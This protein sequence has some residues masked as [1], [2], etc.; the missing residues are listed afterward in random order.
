MDVKK[1]R[2]DM[3][4]S[5]QELADL[6]G[7]PKGRINAWEQRG[8]TPKVDDFKKLELIFNENKSTHINRKP[9]QEPP[10][11]HI[12]LL[13]RMLTL[14]ENQIKE[15]DETIKFQQGLIERCADEQMGKSK[16]RKA[17]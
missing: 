15:K 16:G 3:G 4:L 9:P 5:Q 12:E 13:E 7:I 14:L 10:S 1:L 6:T 17:G 2:E 8:T 11:S